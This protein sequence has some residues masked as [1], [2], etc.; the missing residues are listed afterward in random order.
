MLRTIYLHGELGTKFAPEVRVDVNSV[1][2]AMKALKA[3]FPGFMKH[4]VEDTS[5]YF[6]RL[7]DIYLDKDSILEPINSNDIHLIP[8]VTGSGKMGLIVAGIFLMLMTAGTGSVVLLAGQSA[9]TTTFTLGMGMGTVSLSTA[10]TIGQLG[11]GLLMSGIS[12]L[13]FAPPKQE[14]QNAT[15]NTPNTYFNGSVN[16]IA[17]GNPVSIGYGRLLIGSAVISAG[18]TIGKTA[19]VNYDWLFTANGVDGW[20]I[21][22][23]NSDEFRN[24]NTLIDY[25][26]LADEY[27]YVFKETFVSYYPQDPS[28]IGLSRVLATYDVYKSIYKYNT[29]QNNFT[30]NRL[31]H[32]TPIKKLAIA[33]NT[34]GDEWGKNGGSHNIPPVW[35]LKPASRTTE[36][37]YVPVYSDGGG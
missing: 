33:Q 8:A 22:G 31:T 28:E 12:A 4:L 6:I 37:A 25:N 23:K 16:T 5:G 18:I 19:I 29:Y 21:P 13:L 11:L 17:Q 30:R 9:A 35:G 34:L 14:V 24:A 27:T 7:G 15:E 1:A 3:N 26:S 32:G 36:V 20:Y 10:I 2:E